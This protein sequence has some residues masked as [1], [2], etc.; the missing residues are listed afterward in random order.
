VPSPQVLFCPLT[1]DQ[2]G[3]Y[4]AY[5]N[6]EEVEAIMDGNKDVLGGIDVLK[7]IC[8]HP[9]LLERVANAGNADYGSASRSGKMLVLERVLKLWF[10]QGHRCLLFSQTQQM[11]DILEALLCGLG[12]TYR[13]M[14]GCTAIGSRMVR[15]GG[16]EG[17]L[18]L[19]STRGV[20]HSFSHTLP[21]NLNRI[22]EGVSTGSFPTQGPA[23]S[24]SLHVSQCVRPVLT[25][26][27][28]SP[29]PGCVAAA[30]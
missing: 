21:I 2:R 26:S 16:A 24:T 12:L 9:D 27:L 15:F 18:A 3:V 8:N 6:S 22:S 7:K 11:L 17:S 13:R 23:V 19:A 10:Q 29:N 20:P 25:L 30:D 5:L 14:D 28:P 4:R 1:A